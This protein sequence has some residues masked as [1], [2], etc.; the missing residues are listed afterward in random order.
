[1][2]K[3]YFPCPVRI[4]R[5]NQ[6]A[7]GV[8][9]TPLSRKKGEIYGTEKMMKQQW[10]RILAVWCLFF[11]CSGA[12]L[13]LKAQIAAHGP[14]DTILLGAVIRGR[15]TVAM[16]FLPEHEV[17][18]KLPR[19]W[20]KYA[21][22][23]TKLRMNLEKVYPYAVTAAEVL[24]DVDFNLDRFG[25]NKDARK[26]YLRSIEKELKRRWKGELEDL[27]IT[28]GQ[29]LVKLIDRQTGKNCFSIIKEMK[30]GFTATLWQGVA[31][32]FSNNLKREYDPQGDDKDIEGIVRDIEA[33]N[34]YRYQ[35]AMNRH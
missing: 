32:L 28:Q 17:H 31:M 11:L 22:Y 7:Y 14:N 9:L 10:Y 27:T 1:M 3:G 4:N 26:A 2:G 6:L 20:V 5:H 21:L 30:G 34:Y 19:R 24:K 25:D 15:D 35:A 16:V 29:L 8:T 13:A 23:K 12:P 18:D 33:Q